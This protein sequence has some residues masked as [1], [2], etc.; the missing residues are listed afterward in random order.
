MKYKEKTVMGSFLSWLNKSLL[1]HSFPWV[2]E[3]R[4]FSFE[5][6]GEEKYVSFLD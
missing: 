1:P 2:W 6:R 3:E 5:E 4:P